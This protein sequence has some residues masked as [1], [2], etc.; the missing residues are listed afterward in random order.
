MQFDKSLHQPDHVWKDW[1]VV[2]LLWCVSL[3]CLS[4]NA[5]DFDKYKYLRLA[6]SGMSVISAGLG[7]AKV[8]QIEVE[9]EAIA[10]RRVMRSDLFIET[11]AMQLPSFQQQ[12]STISPVYQQQPALMPVGEINWGEVLN[13]PHL[14]IV[15]ES[16][17]GKTVF[18]QWQIQ[19][20]QAGVKVYDSDAS[21]TDWQG[22]EVIGR[23][24]NYGAIAEAMQADLKELQ[25]RTEMRSRGDE[26]FPPIIRIL[27]EAPETLSSLKDAEYD[28]GYKWL[29]GLLRRGRKYKIK[30]FL[31]SQ[32]F[33]VRALRIDGEGELRDNFRVIRLGKVAIDYCGDA[34]I[35]NALRSTP[36]PVLIEE[37][38]WGSIPDLPSF[39]VSQNSGD[40]PT[41]PAATVDTPSDTDT[42]QTQW[43]NHLYSLDFQP[44]DT[45]TQ[46]HN[47]DPN[48]CPEC[49][50]TDTKGNGYY[51][52]KPRRRCKSCG[53]S[54]VVE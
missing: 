49:G 17:S 15:G 48:T 47:H 35:A 22:L 39:V 14:A 9:S 20:L 50:S 2:V 33:S 13:A 25:R 45:Q 21:P 30:L 8:R 37:D 40:R 32:G 36:R 41:F 46:G 52:G 51:K 7:V 34:V 54:W 19:Q 23:A 28:I 18:T 53:K 42:N 44:V 12:V 43:L 26:S 11:Q 16:G 27:E 5:L 1:L 31:L 4:G 38:C 24:A 3:G 29:K 10:Q 6:L